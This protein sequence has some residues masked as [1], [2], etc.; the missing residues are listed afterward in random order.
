[1]IFRL[2]FLVLFLGVISSCS[3][4]V[5]VGH[6]VPAPPPP[7]WPPVYGEGEPNDDAWNAPWFGT[8][9]PGDQLAIEG[10]IGDDGSDPWDAFAF[11]AGVPC[12][13]EFALTADDPFTDLD[14]WLWD[15]SIG[16]FVA[17]FTSPY[18]PETGAILFDA[19]GTDFELIVRSSFG[20]SSYTLQVAAVNPW[21]TPDLEGGGA[22]SVEFASIRA[23]KR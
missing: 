23:A 5:S 12:L 9:Y 15:P 10:F 11:T 21:E 17:A 7:P 20:F 22:Q 14:V 16:D 18:N 8:L 13:V 4:G 3:G 2:A 6:T 19:Y 1:M